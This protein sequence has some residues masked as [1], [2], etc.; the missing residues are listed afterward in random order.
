MIGH[1]SLALPLSAGPVVFLRR[2]LR[3]RLSDAPLKGADEKGIRM[4]AG[5][6]LKIAL[7][8]KMD[9]G[10]VKEGL[11]DAGENL[12]RRVSPDRLVKLRLNHSRQKMPYA[13]V[14]FLKPQG[15]NLA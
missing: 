14:V 3:G 7:D 10:I 2:F 12:R 5:C 13:C 4:A 1:D 15:S 6:L 9:G 8:E 11:R